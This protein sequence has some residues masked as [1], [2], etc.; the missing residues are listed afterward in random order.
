[1]CDDECVNECVN[2]CDDYCSGSNEDLIPVKM[3]LQYRSFKYHYPDTLITHY[4]CKRHY[5]WMITLN[6][7]KPFDTIQ[8]KDEYDALEYFNYSHKYNIFTFLKETEKSDGSNKYSRKVILVNECIENLNLENKYEVQGVFHFDKK[9][10]I[11]LEPLSY[12]LTEFFNQNDFFYLKLNK[13][14]NRMSKIYF[15]TDKYDDGIKR[16]SVSKNEYNYDAIYRKNESEYVFDDYAY[17]KNKEY[18]DKEYC[19]TL[20]SFLKKRN[21]FEDMYWFMEDTMNK[22]SRFYEVNKYKEYTFRHMLM[23][24]DALS[25]PDNSINLLTMIKQGQ[26]TS[27]LLWITYVKHNHYHNH[28]N[29][30]QLKDN[31]MLISLIIDT[32]SKEELKLF[33]QYAIAGCRTSITYR[34]RDFYNY[35]H[36]NL[37]VVKMIVPKYIDYMEEI[38]CDFQITTSDEND[39]K[40]KVRRP[41]GFNVML[42]FWNK[43]ENYTMSYYPDRGEEHHY[44]DKDEDI[45]EYLESLKKL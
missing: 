15:H 21:D 1:M 23:L 27:E 38:L 9:H 18:F 42:D 35:I 19:D 33:L 26:I 30:I 41:L 3:T 7:G 8:G 28:S 17:E 43:S 34:M 20:Y 10:F 25:N 40:E 45:R 32:F 13:K 39:G 11:E 29:P 4:F 22:L 37:T 31:K 36:P 12:E 6:N 24:E 5:E 16:K 2:K 14:E 44:Y